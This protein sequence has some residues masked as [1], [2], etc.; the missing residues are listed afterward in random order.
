MEMPDPSPTHPGDPAAGSVR[1]PSRAAW[2][3]PALP[4]LPEEVFTNSPLNCACGVRVSPG[5]VQE[6]VCETRR[7]LQVPRSCSPGAAPM[8]LFL[9]GLGCCCSGCKG[10]KV[11]HARYPCIYPAQRSVNLP[12]VSDLTNIHVNLFLSTTPL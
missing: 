10:S 6:P 5:L 2:A 12:A 8:D 11:L 1:A 9:T 4:S 7:P 3:A